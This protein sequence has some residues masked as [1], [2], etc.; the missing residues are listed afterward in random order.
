MEINISV[1][2]AEINPVKSRAVLRLANCLVLEILILGDYNVFGS[3]RTVGANIGE[4]HRECSAG[5]LVM[6]PVPPAV[7]QQS[8]VSKKPFK[9]KEKNS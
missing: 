6:V 1:S 7:I 3:P 2:I 4:I 9:I 5:K 8:A